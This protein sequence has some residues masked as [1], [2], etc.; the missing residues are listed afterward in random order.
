MVPTCILTCKGKKSANDALGTS[1]RIPKEEPNMAQPS[2]RA[3]HILV[4]AAHRDAGFS[5]TI[6]SQKFYEKRLE[7]AS[8]THS[9][10]PDLAASF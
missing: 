10:F 2:C 7:N 1:L 5:R 3:N 6:L 9:N 4:V 8:T